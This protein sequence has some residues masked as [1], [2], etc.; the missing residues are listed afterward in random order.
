M[1]SHYVKATAMSKSNVLTNQ[2][3]V[4][5]S[6]LYKIRHFIKTPAL[7]HVIDIFAEFQILT[8]CDTYMQ[9][10][11]ID[12]NC[13]YSPSSQHPHPSSSAFF[14]FFPH[15]VKCNLKELTTKSTSYV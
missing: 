1:C 10:K 14:Q 13:K 11:L 15:A 9:L 7:I 4:D 12:C 2:S 3:A 6:Q 8:M 5:I